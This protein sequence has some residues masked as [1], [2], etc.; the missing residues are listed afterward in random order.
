MNYREYST[1]LIRLNI[2]FI[3]ILLW[4]FSN[5]YYNFLKNSRLNDIYYS[6]PSSRNT[7]LNLPLSRG[8]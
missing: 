6:V 2:K 7:P 1:K 8:D 3:L 5:E 4:K